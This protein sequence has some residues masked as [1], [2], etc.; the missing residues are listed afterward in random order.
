MAHH[1]PG[2]LFA[3]EDLEGIGRGAKRRIAEDRAELSGWAHHQLQ[4][5]IEYKARHAGSQLLKVDPHYTSQRCPRC[6]AV[7]KSFRKQKEHKYH[8]GVCGYQVN[9]DMAAAMNI[10]ELGLKYLQGE[11]N[12]HFVKELTPRAV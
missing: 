2:T 8:C 10:R 4:F 11:T 3:A 7:N 5:F 12:P 9:D 1:G 6:G